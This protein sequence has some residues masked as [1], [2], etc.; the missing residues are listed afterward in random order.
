MEEDRLSTNIGPDTTQDLETEITSPP[1]Q[2]KRRFVGRKAAE[3]AASSVTTDGN[4]EESSA[5]QG[6]KTPLPRCLNIKV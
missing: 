3:K 5:I 2:P 1:K 6:V 4:I